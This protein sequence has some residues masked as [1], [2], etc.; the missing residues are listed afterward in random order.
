MNGNIENSNLVRDKIIFKTILNSYRIHLQ[1]ARKS[2]INNLLNNCGNN[3]Q[4]LFHTVNRLAS[5]TQ[6]N[7]LPKGDN[8]EL[9]ENFCR[10]FYDKIDKIQKDLEG[11]DNFTPN[12]SNAHVLSNFMIVDYIYVVKTVRNTKSTT[13]FMDSCPA[14]MIKEKLNI[15]LSILLRIINH[16]FNSGSVPE[17]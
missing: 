6:E 14:R 15:L 3:Q 2:F 8:Q 12:S 4:K 11:Y 13:Y 10:Y 9:S 1:H 16:S 5:K 17:E 7:T